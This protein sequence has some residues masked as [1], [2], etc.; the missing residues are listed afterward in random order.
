MPG[1]RIMFN[2]RKHG[3]I[4]DRMIWT[5]MLVTQ[6]KTRTMYV[7]NTNLYIIIPLLSDAISLQIQCL[8]DPNIENPKS[9]WVF[10]VH[11][12]KGTYCVLNQ[13]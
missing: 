6:N 4:N 2:F 1:N 7:A 9:F 8:D 5:H 10:E 3:S 13:E 11:I 12:V